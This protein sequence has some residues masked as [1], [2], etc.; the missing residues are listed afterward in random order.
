MHKKDE[1]D[2]KL[3]C[4]DQLIKIR[5]TYSS[6]TAD[7]LSQLQMSASTFN[8]KIR[9]NTFS[10]AETNMIQPILSKYISCFQKM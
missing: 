5:D 1:K 2:E 8:Y 7:I 9:T 6:I 10:V 4:A 3:S